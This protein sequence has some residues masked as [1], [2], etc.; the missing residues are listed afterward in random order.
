MVGFAG[1]SFLLED[2]V[3]LLFTIAVGKVSSFLN[4]CVDRWD[5]VEGSSVEDVWRFLIAVA[6]I[7]SVLVVH[8]DC[9]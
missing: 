1:K 5:G 7:G 8:R 3:T 4:S 6:Y 9:V 2:P